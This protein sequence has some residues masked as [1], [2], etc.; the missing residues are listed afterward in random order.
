[1]RRRPPTGT[2]PRGTF[3]QNRYPPRVSRFSFPTPGGPGIDGGTALEDYW[4]RIASAQ[5]FCHCSAHCT[6]N[7]MGLVANA[8][9]FGQLPVG[10]TPG[11]DLSFDSIA[12]GELVIRFGDLICSSQA[13]IM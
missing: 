7:C 12:D 2:W 5:A 4:R 9:A 8:L 10:L 1:M 3:W 11:K 6:Q 13:S